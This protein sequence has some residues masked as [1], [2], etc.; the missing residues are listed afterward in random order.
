[1]EKI[2]YAKTTAYMRDT[3]LVRSALEGV[4]LPS[5]I[6]EY[7][8]RYNTSKTLG[9]HN[10]RHMIGVAATCIEFEANLWLK[11]LDRAALLMAAL[12]HDFNHTGTQPDHVNID[13]AI[14]GLHAAIHSD[15]LNIVDYDRDTL[16]KRASVIIACTEFPFVVEPVSDAQKIL[17]D[18][19][20]MQSF[21]PDGIEAIMI[22]L[23]NELNAAG[24]TIR[25]KQMYELQKN[26]Y[27]SATLYT[28]YGKAVFNEMLDAALVGFYQLA[29]SLEEC[30]PRPEL[31]QYGYAPGRYMVKC[32]QCKTTVIDVDKRATCCLNC[33]EKIHKEKHKA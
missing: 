4:A 8:E 14:E 32:G 3:V 26:F 13:K 33:A 9:Y 22:G 29:E 12:F 6:I 28:D 10:N 30:D 2:D 19:D 21:K 31:R 23:R 15:D 5:T 7:L 18:A 27:K 17:R 20:L 24:H 16:F 25:P 1:M 11:D